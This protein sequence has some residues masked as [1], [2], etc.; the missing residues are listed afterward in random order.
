MNDGL[1][2]IPKI[3]AALKAAPAADQRRNDVCFALIYATE[4]RDDMNKSLQLMTQMFGDQ[5]TADGVSAVRQ[6][7]RSGQ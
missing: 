2:E 3:E 4:S 5:T 1:A 6:I 7:I